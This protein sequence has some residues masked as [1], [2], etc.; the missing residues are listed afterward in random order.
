VYVSLLGALVVVLAGHGAGHRLRG[1]LAADADHFIVCE[2]HAAGRSLAEFQQI[3][4]ATLDDI[5]DEIRLAPVEYAERAI[6]TLDGGEVELLLNLRAGLGPKRRIAPVVFAAD[7]DRD[8]LLDLRTR[9][10]VISQDL[11][12]RPEP[13]S[14]VGR[15]DEEGSYEDDHEKR[16]KPFHHVCTSFE[17]GG[18]VERVSHVDQDSLMAR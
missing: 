12:A 17:R 3:F 5:D 1:Q 6:A 18:S 8:H 15:R 4:V 9:H 14:L 2:G 13:R 16:R 11:E 7:R 10:L